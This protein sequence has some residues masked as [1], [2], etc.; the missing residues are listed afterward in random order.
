MRKR[1]HPETRTPCPVPHSTHRPSP[2]AMSAAA[3]YLVTTSDCRWGAGGCGGGGKRGVKRNG[4]RQGA[5][6]ARVRALFPVGGPP[7]ASPPRTLDRSS[8]TS[9]PSEPMAA[10][11][12]WGD[13]GERGGER[14]RWRN[15]V[16]RRASGFHT[17]VRGRPHAGA[18]LAH[19]RRGPAHIPASHVPLVAVPGTPTIAST[20]SGGRQGSQPA[21]RA[22]PQKPMRAAR[23]ARG[24]RS[25]R[26][27]FLPVTPS[28]TLS[29]PVLHA[30]RPHGHQRPGHRQQ[31]PLPGEM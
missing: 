23:R 24:A 29:P 9:E 6:H 21:V 17:C 26:P 5:A 20:G 1:R 15:A 13:G 18:S 8:S 19:A 4:W 16:C 28:L 30:G 27:H 14:V 31:R 11:G 7:P 10:G 2:L 12:G 3:L 25:T 22:R